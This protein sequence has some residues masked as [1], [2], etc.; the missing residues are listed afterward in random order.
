QADLGPWRV[1]AALPF[2]GVCQACDSGDQGRI[3]SCGYEVF[4]AGVSVD[5]L[6]QDRV[7]DLVVGQRVRVQLAWSQFGR[8]WFGD[9]VLRNRGGLTASRRLRI[10]PA[11]KIPHER[12]R[13]VL[14]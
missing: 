7:K 6:G 1:L 14:D 12:L 10:A 9:R 4:D 13:H 2:G 8:R 3:E 11:R 5:V